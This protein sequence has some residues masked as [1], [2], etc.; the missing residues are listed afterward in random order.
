MWLLCGAKFK[1]TSLNLLIFIALF[2]FFCMYTVYSQGYKH[3]TY[4][5]SLTNICRVSIS[6]SNGILFF[7]EIFVKLWFFYFC[8]QNPSL[9]L[10]FLQ[11]MVLIHL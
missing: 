4:L 10:N 8:E 5:Y 3:N 7:T 1:D 2:M 11:E 9:Y 6:Q